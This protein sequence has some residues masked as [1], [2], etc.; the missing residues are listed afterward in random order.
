MTG[1][2]T[3][4]LSIEGGTLAKT[5]ARVF[6]NIF[7]P[8]SGNTAA[9]GMNAYQFTAIFG[10]NTV[11]GNYPLSSFAAVG[12]LDLNQANK[13]LTDNTKRSVSLTDIADATSKTKAA[14]THT[15]AGNT[16][17][18][19]TG[20]YGSGQGSKLVRFIARVSSGTQTAYIAATLYDSAGVF[21][22]TIAAEQTFTLTTTY[23]EFVVRVD[24]SASVGNQIR[25][26]IRIPVAGVTFY[27]QEMNV[28][29]NQA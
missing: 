26:Q 27:I 20:I 15:T 3:F 7:E 10:N 21:V 23:K 22:A 16:T 13:Y 24:N 28:F 8:S 6:D 11:I 18:A 14:V 25:P 2:Y 29:V 4:Q 1:G 5:G 12:Q 9:V 19:F 17:Y